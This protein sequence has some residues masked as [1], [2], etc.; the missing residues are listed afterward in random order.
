MPYAHRAKA[1][2]SK[3]LA[4]Y[5]KVYALYSRAKAYVF[6]KGFFADFLPVDFF[7]HLYPLIKIFVYCLRIGGD[8]ID[9]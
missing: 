6:Y 9:F 2:Y 4:Y 5:K 7:N 1:L 3:V 8:E